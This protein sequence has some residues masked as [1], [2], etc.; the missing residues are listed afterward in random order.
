VVRLA[1]A[2]L[3]VACG[4][5]R[6]EPDRASAPGAL[7]RASTE[8]RAAVPSQGTV[9]PQPAL[10]E[11]TRRR[12]EGLIERW[13]A[14]AGDEARDRAARAV[15]SEGKPAL[16]LLCEWLDRG[17]D[18]SLDAVSQLIP[19][20]G[21]EAVPCLTTRLEGSDEAIARRAWLALGGVQAICRDPDVG[22][23]LCRALVARLRR[24]PA[25]SD[26]DA[27]EFLRGVVLA[28]RP[29]AG[30]ILELWKSD[31]SDSGRT[32]SFLLARLGPDAPGA[33]RAALE[34]LRSGDEERK[35]EAL[36][37][38]AASAGA[39]ATLLPEVAALLG[40]PDA[41]VRGR[42]AAALPAW[43]AAADAHGAS[44]L[45]L[46]DDP[47]TRRPALAALSFMPQFAAAHLRPIVAADVLQDCGTWAGANAV[48]RLAQD[49][50]CR[51]ALT[52][53]LPDL[54]AALHVHVAEAL[55]PEEPRTDD[56]E[57][58][59]ARP[60]DDSARA[61]VDADETAAWGLPPD[62]ELVARLRAAAARR[63]S[64][65]EEAA[66]REVLRDVLRR[67]GRAGER[68]PWRAVGRLLPTLPWT[69]AD[70]DLLLRA[71]L[72]AREESAIHAFAPTIER[73]G[74]DAA[75]FVPALRVA[76]QESEF[77]VHFSISPGVQPAGPGVPIVRALAAIGAAARPALPELRRWIAVTEDPDGSGRAAVR[78]IES[79]A[80]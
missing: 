61:S 36:R 29:L 46:L 41:D 70:R 53:L 20:F 50:A 80:R 8:P 12:I 68:V 65:G 7:P 47:D 39:D 2:L 5:D 67:T 27:Y 22:T 58:P 1:S 59:A 73:L 57:E 3:L 37:I 40:H 28:M 75:A 14:A 44:V 56:G 13:S 42:A 72:R 21:E 26:W 34:V 19:R 77:T 79:A 25:A 74:P 38:F 51:A 71:F 16:D 76:L 60:E 63:D 15:V 43:G 10:D 4:A 6:Q 69:G 62:A 33:D 32:A 66:L 23:P 54:E 52:A 17:G 55:A 48:E 64:T 45:P 9:A 18:D 11:A 49:A 24:K 31:R 30:E 78:A 35:E